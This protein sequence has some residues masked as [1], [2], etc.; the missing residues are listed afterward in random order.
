MVMIKDIK[1]NKNDERWI[2]FNKCN[3]KSFVDYIKDFAPY[4]AEYVKAYVKNSR[5]YIEDDKHIDVDKY[6]YNPIFE[7]NENLGKLHR[8]LTCLASYLAVS[9]ANFDNVCDVYPVAA[10]IE[11]FQTAALIH[12]D[13]ADGGQIRRGKP[14]M[15]KVYGDGLAINAG[16]FGL[17]LVVGS[18]I[19]ASKKCNYSGKKVLR[20]IDELVKMEYS[21]IEGQAMDLGWAKDKRF[22]ILEQDYLTMAQ[23]KTAF[24]SAA[25]PCVLGAIC[26]DAT[27]AVVDNMREFGKRVGLAFQIQDDILNLIDLG[28][29]SFAKN[30]DFR[31]DITEGKR[32]LLV[33]KALELSSKNDADNLREILLSETSDKDKLDCAVEIIEKSGSLEYANSYAQK[34]SDN[35][36]KYLS[37]LP[38]SSWKAL[39][40]DMATWTCKR[41]N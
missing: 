31:S 21:T 30:K 33:V 38:E 25:I 19:Q 32:T 35:A 20:I 17:S 6:L 40:L 37:D 16:D 13:I 7:Y 12:D 18:V 14:C 8:P 1:L 27:D 22:D 4:F 3:Y 26:A 36:K 5:T 24:Y 23:K 10:A 39:L 29:G 11:H 34:L 9:N 28:D 2:N 41:V 15:H